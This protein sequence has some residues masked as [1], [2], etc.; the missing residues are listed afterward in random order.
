M[1]CE[2]PN[3]YPTSFE[4]LET[5]NSL[6]NFENPTCPTGYIFYNAPNGDCQDVHD[7]GIPPTTYYVLHKGS[8]NTN[9][10]P[11]PT[12]GNSIVGWSVIVHGEGNTPVTTNVATHSV[13]EGAAGF[14]GGV[15][16]CTAV[17]PHQLTFVDV[18]KVQGIASIGNHGMSYCILPPPSTPSGVKISNIGPGTF[19]ATWTPGTGQTSYTYTL[20]G[21]SILPKSDNG[22]SKNSAIFTNVPGNDSNTLVVNAVNLSGSVSSAPSDSFSIES[23]TIP[24]SNI[25]GVSIESSTTS[26]SNSSSQMMLYAG[27]GGVVL[28]I[29]IL[30]LMMGGKK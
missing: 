19:T 26:E 1:N 28:I 11:D 9:P 16:N 15:P 5:L 29:F 14:K 18:K 22:M 20:N 23:I 21:D 7:P 4:S 17:T 2:L 12:K 25:A 30:M 10:L 3:C 27:I 13:A 6:E 8:N 24:P